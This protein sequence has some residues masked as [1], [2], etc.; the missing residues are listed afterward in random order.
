MTDNTQYYILYYFTGSNLNFKNYCFINN[1][2]IYSLSPCTRG[3]LKSCIS[4]LGVGEIATR[5]WKL[6][7]LSLI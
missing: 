2:Y 7:R 1:I 6:S 3:D 4:P 5:H